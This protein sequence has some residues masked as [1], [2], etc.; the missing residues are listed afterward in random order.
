MPQLALVRVDGL[1]AANRAFVARH[2]I[3]VLSASFYR[4]KPGDHFRSGF[5]LDLRAPPYRRAG[6]PNE[7]MS[8]PAV[9]AHNQGVPARLFKIR[10]KLRC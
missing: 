2:L 9:S 8:E 4:S 3:C 6:V 1:Y 10:S 7:S 5:R